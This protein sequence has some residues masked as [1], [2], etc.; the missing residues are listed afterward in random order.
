MEIL[1]YIKELLLL[2]DCV[3]IP[4]FGGF[5]SNYKSASHRNAQFAPPTKAISF[6]EKLKFNDGLLINHLVEKEGDNY[7]AA[8]KKVDLLV[9]EIDYRLTDGETIQIDGVG[10]LVYD[11]NESLV[12]NPTISE[13]LN[14]DAYG[15]GAFSFETLYEQKLVRTQISQEERDVVQVFFQKRTLKKVLVA[16]PLLFALAVVP[17]KNNTGNLQKSNLSSLTEMM[18]MRESVQKIEPRPAVVEA[19]EIMAD[20]A[21][22]NAYFIIG[23]SFRNGHNADKFVK[24]KQAEGFNAQNIGVIKGLHYIALG[25][26]ANFEQAKNAQAK[27]KTES[28]GSGVWIY[29][30]K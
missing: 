10:E 18:T 9:Q 11:Q 27:I 30:Q 1:A 6:N 23:G 13:N 15:L 7:L 26:F 22:N 21:E 14:L 8:S 20:Q 5:V 12:F 24:Q 19:S 2:N 17:I 4:G 3:I 25:N 28:P 16:I 29:V